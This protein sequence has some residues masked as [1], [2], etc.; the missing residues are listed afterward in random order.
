MKYCLPTAFLVLAVL[1]P[2]RAADGPVIDTMDAVHFHAPAGKGKAELVPGKSGKAVRFSFAA[3]GGAFFT[4]PVHATPDWDSAAGISFWLKGDG[5]DHFGGL[6]LIYDE[7]YAVRYDYAFPLKSTR[8][9]KV[10]IPWRDLVPVLPGPKCKPL[11]PRT[12][13]KPS[14]ITG[15]WLGKW[16]Y[17][18]T[19]PAV[20][21]T[22]DEIRLEPKI[23]FDTR[24]YRPKGAPLARVL[25]K[26][27]AGRPVTIVTMGDSLTDYHHWANRQTS[28]PRLLKEQLEKRY[29][30]R[31]T[32]IN[33]AIGG[34][35]LRQ[36]LVL[37]PRWLAQAPQP[38]LVTVCFGFNDWDAGMRG[39]QFRESYDDAVDR[40]RR[41][42]KG[43]ADVLILTTAPAASRWGVM[44]ELSEACRAAARDRNA[45][46]ADIEKRFLEAG[47][48]DK[49]RLYVDDRTHLSPAGHA[50]VAE[51]VR[52]VTEAAGR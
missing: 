19:Y 39:R 43:H 25:A 47:K 30:S 44:A 50:L 3:G 26:L 15:L 45:G 20:S 1:T 5:S 23:D 48:R 29:K 22:V 9:T 28:W 11:G 10:V 31:V 42:T 16:W 46:L 14:K 36:N 35:Q 49:E 12:G 4:R 51:T 37:V 2:A 24:D 32:I 6:E 18:G 33:P 40:I 34:T 38:D 21:F 41:A 13:N 17:W 52:A 7:D 8:W 27:K